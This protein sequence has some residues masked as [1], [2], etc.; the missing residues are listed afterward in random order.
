VKALHGKPNVN[1]CS[2]LLDNNFDKLLAWNKET[3]WDKMIEITVWTSPIYEEGKDLTEASYHLKQIL[4]QDAPYT[5]YTKI[6]AFFD[7]IEKNLLKKYEQDSVMVGCIEPFKF[8]VM[9]GQ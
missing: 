4:A 1:E 9:Q 2:K 3:G 5:S 8:A 6:D 7:A